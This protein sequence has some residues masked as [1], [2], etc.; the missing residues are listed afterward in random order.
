[1]VSPQHQES[2]TGKLEAAQS[3][4]RVVPLLLPSPSPLR[5]SSSHD[6]NEAPSVLAPVALQLDLDDDDEVLDRSASVAVSEGG[7]SSISLGLRPPASLTSVGP[8]RANPRMSALGAVL[9][10]APSSGV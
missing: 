6:V 2:F 9:K 7:E 5:N 10:A 3:V 4:H 1:V 8:R